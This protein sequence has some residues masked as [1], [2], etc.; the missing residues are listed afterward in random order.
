MKLC[1]VIGKSFGDEGKGLATDY[2]AARAKSRGEKCLV[3]RHNGG[4]QA[5][6]TVDRENDRFVFHQLSSG[7]FRGA[8]SFWA[9]TFLPDMYKLSEE[10]HSFAAQ[11]GIN[12]RIYA[13]VNCRSVII[14]DV[15]INMARET[16]RDRARHGSCGMGINEAVKRSAHPEFLLPLGRLISMNGEEL[17][18]ELRRIRREYLPMRTEEIDEDITKAGEVYELLCDDNVLYNL[19]E[20]MKRSCELVT[21][22]EPHLVHGYDTVIF[23]GAQGLLLDCDNISYAPHLT[24]SKTDSTNPV[25]FCRKHLMGESL[26]RVYVSRSYVTRHGAGSLPMER[27]FDISKYHINDLTNIANE[28]QGS[29]R[30]APHP[31]SEAFVSDIQRDI[32]TSEYMGEISLFITHLNETNFCIST[33]SG[34]M[35]VDDWIREKPVSELFDRIYLSDSPFSDKTKSAILT[36]RA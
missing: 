28:W 10:Y 21:P 23:E 9:D 25:A 5:G 30:F 35:P 13:D 34:D 32:G 12:V 8:D 18:R 26:E 24:T 20:A 27:C 16:V 29:L 31:L 14:D 7:S 4:A 36:S 33:V 17:C 3:I 22:S 11:S 1:A 15:L 6:H 19:A 2:F